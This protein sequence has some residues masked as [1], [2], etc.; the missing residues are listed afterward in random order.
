MMES[1]NQ[2]LH[3]TNGIPTFFVWKNPNF[4][5]ISSISR[6]QKSISHHKT[7]ERHLCYLQWM[8]HD[9]VWVLQEIKRQ[10][11]PPATFLVPME[12]LCWWMPPVILGNGRQNCDNNVKFSVCWIW[13]V[14]IKVRIYFSKRISKIVDHAKCS[15]LKGAPTKP[16][17]GVGDACVDIAEA[18]QPVEGLGIRGTE[19]Q[20]DHTCW[21]FRNPANKPV[22]GQVVYLYMCQVV[23]LGISEPWTVALWLNLATWPF[24]QPMKATECIDVCLKDFHGP[25]RFHQHELLSPLLSL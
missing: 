23:G 12:V 16:V 1:Q 10:L 9:H 2:F 25:I 7:A 6:W 21:W 18:Q 13:Q 22:E 19:K 15:R 4:F 3:E 24:D 14:L 17:V 20:L 11:W 5:K 8:H